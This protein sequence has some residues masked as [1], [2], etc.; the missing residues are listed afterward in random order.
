M[1]RLQILILII[2]LLAIPV[3]L[4][5]IGQSQIFKGR[6]Q[7]ASSI[8]F[9][10]SGVTQNNPPSTSSQTVQLTLTYNGSVSP[11]PPPPP[12]T[13]SNDSCS[14]NLTEGQTLTGQVSLLLTAVKSNPA[15]Y[16]SLQLA[17]PTL[18]NFQVLSSQTNILF[19]NLASNLFPNGR[20][21][22]ECRIQTD[23]TGGTIISSRQINVNIQN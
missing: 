4:Y 19:A 8:Q 21:T 12:P 15:Y 18:G 20:A 6:A 2:L 10:G 13:T 5:L 11:A 3:S 17:S 22:L 7:V 23:P 9:S 16:L 1:N 14:F